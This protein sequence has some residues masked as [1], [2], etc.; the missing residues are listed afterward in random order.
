MTLDWVEKRRPMTFLLAI[1]IDAVILG[2]RS[3]VPYYVFALTCCWYV[4]P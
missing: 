2:W 1:S 3:V 4:G